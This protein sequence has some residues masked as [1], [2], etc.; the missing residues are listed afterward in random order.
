[1]VVSRIYYEHVLQVGADGKAQ[2]NKLL[3]EAAYKT[4]VENDK[5]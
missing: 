3:D 1:M 4:H 5:H 2:F